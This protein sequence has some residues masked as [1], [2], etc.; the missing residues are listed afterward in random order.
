MSSKQSYQGNLQ[1]RLRNL[2]MR[3]SCPTRQENGQRY[4][5]PPINWI[6]KAP[7]N[8]EIFISKLPADC[9]EDEIYDFCSRVGKIY[10]IR[11]MINFENENR[12]FCF[13]TFS[14]SKEAEEA[15]VLLPQ[16]PLR[17]GHYVH[18]EIS[19]NNCTLKMYGLDFRW[20]DENL[21]QVR[22]VKIAKFTCFVTGM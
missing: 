5:G 13:V 6:E 7:T 4:L 16:S 17:K 1:E 14:S 2:S 18:A 10:L 12:G 21:E 3:T 9:Y 19:F 22:G 20:N 15:V 11:L 8:A